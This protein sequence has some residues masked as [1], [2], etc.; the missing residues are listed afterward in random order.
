M[1]FVS[2]YVCIYLLWSEIAM[3]LLED[4]R[5]GDSAPLSDLILRDGPLGN[6][7][8]L[9]PFIFYYILILYYVV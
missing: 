7:E 3:D 2:M 6:G 4:E 8:L 5:R 9:F 1:G